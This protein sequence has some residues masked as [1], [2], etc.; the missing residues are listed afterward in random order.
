MPAPAAPVVAPV[1]AT[2]RAVIVGA[3]LAA[4]YAALALAPRGVVIVSP[5]PLGESASSAWAQGGVAAAV[6][7]G[8]SPAQ[9]AADTLRAGAGTV[10]AEVAFGVTRERWTISWPWPTAARRSIGTRR[11]ASCCRARPPTAGRGSCGCAATGPG[12]RSWRR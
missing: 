7:P 10:D 11:A 4:L 3:G 9:H 8:D 6:G 12:T 5:G 1:F 2:D